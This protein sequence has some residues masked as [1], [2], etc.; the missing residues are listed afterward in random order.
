M[1]D[2]VAITA[3]AGTTVA[4]DDVSSVHFQKVKLVDGTADSSAAIPGDATNGLDVDVTRVQG[5]V[6]VSGTVTASNTTGDVASGA[7]NG[8]NPVQIGI[9]AI[10][11]GSNPSAVTAGQRTKLYAN[12]AGIPFQ[13]GGH[14]NV[15]TSSARRADSDNGVTDGA[16]GPGTVNTGT[17]VVV[18][19][20]TVA[21][22]N[23]NTVNVACKV[24]F[25]ASSIP[26]DSTTG[27][28]GVL[29]DHEGIPPGGGFTIG[30][31]S[32]ILGI[33]ADGEELR[34]TTDDPVGGHVIISVSYYTIES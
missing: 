14:P 32:G 16:I 8:G 33:G 26:A 25:G 21:C 17:K 12:R 27:A 9:E 5:T 31:G 20:L 24:G 18:T 34:W 3:G 2:N 1:A 29:M 10:A 23:A 28:A 15:V 30:D 4:T 13:I 11:H 6:T 7:T 22:S 19:R